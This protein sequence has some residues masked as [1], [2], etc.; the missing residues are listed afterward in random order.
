M[1]NRV[2]RKIDLALIIVF[3]LVF[4]GSVSYAAFYGITSYKDK[5]EAKRLAEMVSQNAAKASSAA[6]E[7]EEFAARHKAA[8][9]ASAE[10]VSSSGK[11][12]MLPELKPLYEMNKDMIGW[13][14]IDGTNINLPVMYTPKDPQHYLR[15]DFQKKYRRCGLPFLDGKTV[16]GKSS[17]YIIYGHNMTDGTAFSDLEKFCEENFYKQH[18]IIHFNTLYEKN[19]YEIISVMLSKVYTNEDN[20]FKYYNF[21]Y[22]ATE[23]QFNRFVENAKKHSMYQTGVNAVYGDKLLTL[24]TCSYHTEDGRLAVIAKKIS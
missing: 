9:A 1:P 22:K 23:K 6:E 15:L 24:S 16:L 20:T 10:S 7:Q 11:P 5:E 19:D 4:I 14:S 21:N 2:R 17:N 8:K 12:Q 18:T 3:S 13:V